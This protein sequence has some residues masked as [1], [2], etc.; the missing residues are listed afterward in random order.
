M[1]TRILHWVACAGWAALA[2]CFLVGCTLKNAGPDLSLAKD[3][4]SGVAVMEVGRTGAIE[5]NLFARMKN[6]DS[7]KWYD[8][9]VDDDVVH[10]DFGQV[11]RPDA[12]HPD[13]S[14]WGYVPASE[15]LERLVVM[16]LPPGTYEIANVRGRSPRFSVHYATLYHLVSENVNV[17]FTVRA[18]EIS[19]LGGIVFSFPDWISYVASGP[20]RVLMPDTRGRDEVLLREQYPNLPASLPERAVQ[21]PESD[22]VFKYYLYLESEGTGDKH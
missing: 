11:R 5:F 1:N 2:G 12:A 9:P 6:L 3:P 20:L 19:Y 17:R 8:L 13:A 10:M 4:N 18:G 22:R 16:T 7:G 21:G 15:P 14:G